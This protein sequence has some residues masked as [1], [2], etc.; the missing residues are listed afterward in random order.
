M[1][2]FLIYPIITMVADSF[3][4]IGLTGDRTFLKTVKEYIAVHCD[5]SWCGDASGTTVRSVF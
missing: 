4:D 3:F 1:G 5:C 2:A